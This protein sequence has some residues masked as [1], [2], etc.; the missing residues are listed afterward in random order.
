ME[1]QTDMTPISVSRN[2]KIRD[3]GFPHFVTFTTVNW[4]DI[5]TR[6]CYKECLI[7]SLKYC[8]ANKGL[9]LYGYCFMTN[10]IHLI[11][12]TK[13]DPMQGIIRDFKAFTSRQIKLSIKENASESRKNWLLWMFTNAGIRNSNNR[14]WQFWQQSSHPIELSS[15]FLQDQKLEYI[16]QNPVKAGFVD[17]SE[18]WIWSSARNYMGV[19]G[20][21]EVE[22]LG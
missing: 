21:I 8:Q 10:H 22:Y 1:F 16:H 19:Q 13:K 2:Y 9:I 15:N 12:G 7:E 3:Q 18:D 4:I 14:D 17:K 11:I 20:L 6:N 5:F